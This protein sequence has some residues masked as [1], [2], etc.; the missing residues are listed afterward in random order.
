MAQDSAE[1]LIAKG[2]AIYAAPRGTTLPADTDP[3]DTLD[4]AFEDVGYVNEDGAAFSSPVSLLEIMAWQSARPIRRD[5]ETRDYQI[6]FNCE[7]FNAANLT[8]A[9]AGGAGA[10]TDPGVV[11][12]DFPGDEDPLDEIALVVDW[13]DRGY[14]YRLV[15]EDGNSTEGFDTSLVRTA[16]AL[17]PVTYKALETAPFLVTDDPGFLAGS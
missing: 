1:V 17:I 14:F 5:V 10:E 11:R 6:A 2:G 9:L 4:A 16:A 12:F 3:R 15:Y 7:Q 8:L 13:E